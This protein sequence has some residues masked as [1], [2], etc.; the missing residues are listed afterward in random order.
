MYYDDEVIVLNSGKI[1]VNGLSERAYTV[2]LVFGESLTVSNVFS[3]PVST[4]TAPQNGERTEVDLT[5][6]FVEGIDIGL[7][8]QLVV[9][10]LVAD[11]PPIGTEPVTG[12]AGYPGGPGAGTAVL[13]GYFT[14][15]E[16]PEPGSNADTE[17]SIDIEKQDVARRQPM[18]QGIR[19]PLL[20]NRH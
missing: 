13:A 7:V 8:K 5:F 12:A 2:W 17:P 1:V 18:R 11:V 19:S 3:V 20:R 6:N 14:E 16:N 10:S 4:F 9:T 15:N